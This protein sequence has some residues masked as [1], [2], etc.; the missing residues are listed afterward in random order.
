[1]VELFTLI[2]FLLMPMACWNQRSPLGLE[3]LVMWLAFVV[4]WSS[5]QE[6]QEDLKHIEKCDR[7]LFFFFL[8]NVLV[9]THLPRCLQILLK[10]FSAVLYIGLL[11]NKFELVWGRHKGPIMDIYLYKQKRIF[12]YLIIITIF[13]ERCINLKRINLWFCVSY[14]FQ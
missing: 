10:L 14:Y 9:T 1:M 4:Y 5:A 13:K 11:E 7:I 8:E 2:T 3:N 6:R 12:P